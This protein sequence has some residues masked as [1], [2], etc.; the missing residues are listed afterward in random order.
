MFVKY[1]RLGGD[2]MFCRSHVTMWNESCWFLRFFF[3]C[4]ASFQKRKKSAYFTLE[5]HLIVNYIKLEIE[6]IFDGKILK[7]TLNSK[8]TD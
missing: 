5:A 4:S 2:V 7:E 1:L 3:F 8:S 6:S